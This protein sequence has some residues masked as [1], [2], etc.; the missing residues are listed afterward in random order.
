MIIYVVCYRLNGKV[1]PFQAKSNTE[2]YSYRDKTDAI[3]GHANIIK[4]LNE[5]LDGSPTKIYGHWGYQ[6]TERKKVSESDKEGWTMMK[7]TSFIKEVE[8]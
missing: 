6:R 3:V 8:L 7:E 5:L 2:C 1:I 4:Q